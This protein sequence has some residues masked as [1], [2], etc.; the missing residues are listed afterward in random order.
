MLA[1]NDLKKGVQIIIDDQPYEVL[2]SSHLKKAQRRV[3]IQ[4]K[5]RNLITGG[6]FDRNFHQGDVFEEAG[7]SRITAKFMY[8]H[9]DKYF[10]SEAENPSKRFDLTKEQI[11]S[12]LK[13]LKPNQLVDGLIFQNKIISVSLP[14]KIQLKV[15]EAPPG[16]RG[17][18]AQGG[19]KIAALETG[20]KINVPLFINEGDTIEINTQEETYVRRIEKQ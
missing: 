8:V 19:T 9:R 2:E 5:I 16:V 15:T 18:R 10:F 20:A 12:A 7:L 17:D 3:V 13:F 1:H 14:I 4:T 6:V 11:G